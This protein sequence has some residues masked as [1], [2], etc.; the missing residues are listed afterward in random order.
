M[1]QNLSLDYGSH[2][3]YLPSVFPGKDRIIHS[4]VFGVL[5]SLYA[6]FQIAIF[7][8][9]VTLP[10]NEGGFQGFDLF[11]VS[12]A[13]LVSFVI[14]LI[15]SIISKYYSGPNWWPS[16]GNLILLAAIGFFSYAFAFAAAYFSS[17]IFTFT[18]NDCSKVGPELVILGQLTLSSYIFTTGSIRILP[19]NDLSKRNKVR[20]LEFHS[21]RWWKVVIG[22]SFIIPVAIGLVSV[23]TNMIEG[24]YLGRLFP[25]IADFSAGFLIGVVIVLYKQK[26][27]E[28]EIKHTLE[29]L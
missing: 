26:Q 2:S 10:G 14:W 4:I 1:A 15:T 8:F 11:S 24:G 28:E 27:I 9:V 5:I 17:T 18:C 25:L 3:E 22:I 29:E 19:S 20:Y 21:S 13:F 7:M 23:I 12:Y 6:S 16:L